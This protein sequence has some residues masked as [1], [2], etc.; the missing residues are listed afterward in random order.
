MKRT[1]YIVSVLACWLICLCAYSLTFAEIVEV[2]AGDGV[3]IT[4][5]MKRAAIN[6][7][8]TDLDGRVMTNTA[9]RAMDLVSMA[10]ETADRIAADLLKQDDLD[11]P[12]QAEAEAGV[13]TTERVWTPQRIAQA[14][15]A[16]ASGTGGEIDI[17]ATTPTVGQTAVWVDG[18]TLE[19]V[20]TTEVGTEVEAFLNA[21]N[22]NLLSTLGAEPSNA[23]ILK[24]ADIDTEAE[25]E[26]V[27]FNLPSGSSF[28]FDTYP[29]YE[30]SAHSSNLA[31]N[32]TH[33][34]VYSEAAGEWGEIALDFST[35]IGTPVAPSTPTMIISGAGPQIATFTYTEAITASTTADLCDDWSIS[36]TTAGALTFGYTSGDTGTAIVCTV[37]ADV[38]DDD[39]VDTASY[40]Q[41]TIQANDDNELMANIADFSSAITNSSSESS[42]GCASALSGEVGST[43]STIDF[44]SEAGT[45]FY[46]KVVAGI[47]GNATEMVAYLKYLD[48]GVELVRYA[49]Y[50][51]NGDLL[52]STE[53]VTNSSSPLDVTAT[54]DGTVCITSGET[55][56][57][58]IQQDTALKVYTEADTGN[59]LWK[60]TNDFANGFPGTINPGG[61]GVETADTTFNIRLAP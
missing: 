46:T 58:A 13:A 27:L 54:L 16:L 14:I 4:E 25:F 29:T 44:S 41:G 60:V 5:G 19:G 57:L 17:S 45:F 26:S 10:A 21:T 42:G 12:S 33:F 35:L 6:D 38:F 31:I 37:D 1:N 61:D 20:D 30:D 43:P 47:T 56:Y 18:D 7:N 40:S 22:G 55:Y 9:N 50:A 51:T 53:A 11:V 49:V 2:P 52:E 15:A 48:D 59:N 39:T 8:F 23:T 24:V 34:A 3:T 36:M 32:A 28:N